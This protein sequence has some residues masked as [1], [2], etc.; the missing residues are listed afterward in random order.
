VDKHDQHATGVKT[1]V[2]AKYE[3]VLPPK[4]S[5]VAIDGENLIISALKGAEDDDGIIVRFWNSS[6]KTNEVKI[7]RSEMKFAWLVNLLEKEKQ[8]LSVDNGVVTLPVDAKKIV[9]V[10]L[11]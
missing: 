1:Y 4:H 2:T 7:S 6:D 9:T 5:F 11:S 8:E 10:K 3:G